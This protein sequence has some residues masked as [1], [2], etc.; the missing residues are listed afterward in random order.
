MSLHESL[1]LMEANAGAFHQV[2]SKL[3]LPGEHRNGIPTGRFSRTSECS[4]RGIGD[5]DPESLKP[6]PEGS[7]GG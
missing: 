3:N 1:E 6:K 2:S 7:L 5:L 4:R